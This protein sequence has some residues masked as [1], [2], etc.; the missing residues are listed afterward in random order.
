MKSHS[1]SRTFIFYDTS[2][3]CA[4]TFF[5]SL[6]CVPKNKLIYQNNG[7]MCE[8]LKNSSL[9]SQRIPLPLLVLSPSFFQCMTF[10]SI[11]IIVTYTHSQ[12]K[13]LP[14][15]FAHHHH[16]KTLSS[17]HSLLTSHW[18]FAS[19]PSPTPLG[20]ATRT[21]HMHTHSYT[22]QYKLE[23][24][25]IPISFHPLPTLCSIICFFYRIFLK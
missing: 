16:P 9:I 21:L 1:K 2:Q 25:H 5:L 18:S 10:N 3:Y 24:R 15:F 6:V 17:L 7:S 14:A 13:P 19:C 23:S 11:F 4:S 20:F 12:F 22:L 8:S